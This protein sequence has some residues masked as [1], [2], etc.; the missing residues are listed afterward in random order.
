MVKEEGAPV[1]EAAPG[2]AVAAPAAA[3]AAPAAAEAAPAAA[4][5]AVK[6]EAAPAAGHDHVDATAENGDRGTT[7]VQSPVVRPPRRSHVPAH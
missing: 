6:A 7:G 1:A 4:K 5:A 2:V 3:E